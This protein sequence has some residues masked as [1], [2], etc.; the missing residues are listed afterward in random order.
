MSD[1]KVMRLER[2]KQYDGYFFLI[3]Q[4]CKAYDWTRRNNKPDHWYR[5]IRCA[6]AYYCPPDLVDTIKK[7]IEAAGM[8]WEP[9]W[10]PEY[11]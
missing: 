1:F 9:E 4:T 3:C 5:M 11:N 2:I 6:G 10:K 7:E 8:T